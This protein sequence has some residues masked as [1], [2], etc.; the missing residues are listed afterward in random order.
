MQNQEQ[1]VDFD[2]ERA[3]TYDE[4]AAKLA[5]LSDALHSNSVKNLISE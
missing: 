1:T 2:E 5:L 3:F 4:R